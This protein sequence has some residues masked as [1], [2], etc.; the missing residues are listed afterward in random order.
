MTVADSLLD[1]P[2]PHMGVSVEEATVSAWH[3]VVGDAIEVDQPICDVSTDKVDTEVLSPVA[4][5]VAELVIE[6]G[7][8]VKVGTPLLRV[9]TGSTGSAGDGAGTA[10]PPA[11]GSHALAGAS[12]DVERATAEVLGRVHRDGLLA[13]PVARRLAAARGIALE[14]ITG[15]GRGGRISKRDAEGA[16][17]VQ[18]KPVAPPLEL[19]SLADGSSDALPRGY[20]DVPYE[21]VPTTRIRRAIAE[22]MVR[23]RQTAAHMTTEC[24]VDM[25]HASLVRERLNAERARAGQGRVSFLACI[26]RAAVA[27]LHDFPDLNATF[28]GERILRWHEVNVGIAVDTPDGLLAPVIRRA[29]RLTAGAIADAIADLGAR[30]RSREL[31]ADDMR[32]GTFTISNPGSLGAV[33]APAIINQ[34]Q[35]AILGVPAIVKRPWVVATADGSDAIVPRP[36]MNLA[37]TFDH[38]AVDGAEATRY[39]VRVKELLESWDADAYR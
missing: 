23:S 21:A 8:S 34:P 24:E 30:A 16:A 10:E 36:I 28:Q 1:V 25:H 15:T 7:G 4:G 26:T 39:V 13:S 37:L 18:P 6:A 5:T 3:V 20:I 19:G 27:A 31:A 38:R 17:A 12:I 2:M 11:N 14:S 22:H 9:S 29:E 35:V 33:S 32:A